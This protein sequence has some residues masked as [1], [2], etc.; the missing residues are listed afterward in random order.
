MIRHR[1]ARLWVTS[2]H[3]PPHSVASD[4]ERMIH[5]TARIGPNAAAAAAITAADIVI[6]PASHSVA[7]CAASVPDALVRGTR[8]LTAANPRTTSCRFRYEP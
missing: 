5:C 7:I 6:R 4:I 2:C 1:T 3:C 8:E